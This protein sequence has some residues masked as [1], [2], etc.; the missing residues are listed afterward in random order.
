MARIVRASIGVMSCCYVMRA[1][2]TFESSGLGCEALVGLYG[3]PQ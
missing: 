3:W 1:G 2:Q